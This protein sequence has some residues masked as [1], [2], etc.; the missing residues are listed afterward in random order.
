MGDTVGWIRWRM[1]MGD[2][3]EDGVEVRVVVVA[4]LL[5]IS[6]ILA[7]YMGAVVGAECLKLLTG[8]CYV[9]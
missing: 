6:Y 4:V 1:G 9:L 8:G 7:L 3:M 5:G 2:A